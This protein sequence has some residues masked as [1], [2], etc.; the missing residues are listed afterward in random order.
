M[1][2][3]TSSSE[4]V[5]LTGKSSA[6]NR[7][8]HRSI[9]LILAGICLIGI[10]AEAVTLFA[11]PR[12]SKIE[13]RIDEEY[14]GALALP[15]YAATGSPTMLLLGNSLL[16]EGVDLNS[17]RTSVS[18]KYDVHRLVIEQTEF[19]DLYYLLRKVFRDGSRPHDV[20]LCLSVAHLIGN[21]NRGEFM[22]SYMDAIDLAALNRRQGMDPTTTS[23]YFFAHW[24]RWYARRAEI[25]KVLLSRLMP[26]AGNL[27]LVL[28][29]RPAPQIPIS[30]IELKSEP[31][32]RELKELCDRYGSRLTILVPPSVGEDNAN[33]LVKVGDK[34]GVRVL[35]P[36]QPGELDRT[37]FRDGFHLTPAGAQ[38][39]TAKLAP[40]L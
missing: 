17:L 7:A 34:V 25:R 10:A 35:V 27:A 3:S 4:A 8:S 20:V 9:G 15:A 28:G 40:E 1:P 22:A 6:D 37:M 38:V 24:S 21:D 18:G 13:H 39:F 23:N 19:L 32:W 26:D 5:Q 12:L 29:Y 31:R 14:S 16:L 30:E 36:E 2:S 33:A 11:L